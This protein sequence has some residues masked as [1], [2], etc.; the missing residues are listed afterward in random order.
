ML[1][2]QRKYS[3]PLHF[4]HYQLLL[5]H[6]KSSMIWCLLHQWHK[7]HQRCVLKCKWKFWLH[8]KISSISFLYSVSTWIYVTRLDFHT[9]AAIRELVQQLSKWHYCFITFK[10]RFFV[11][12][13]KFCM[14]PMCYMS[15]N[16]ILWFLSDG[17]RIL[18]QPR[19]GLVFGGRSNVRI[20]VCEGL[21]LLVRFIKLGRRFRIQDDFQAFSSD[22]NF[23]QHTPIDTYWQVCLFLH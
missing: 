20:L 16:W 13:T 18:P 23:I 19:S 12:Y 22:K 6:M 2:S 15:F 5:L 1:S 14:F 4:I 21:I 7:W 11:M 8:E 9:L 10:S 3:P 17:S